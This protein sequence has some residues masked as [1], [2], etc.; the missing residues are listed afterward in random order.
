MPKKS[1]KDNP[2]LAFIGNTQVSEPATLTDD[3][4]VSELTL[5][6]VF[7]PTPAE[8]SESR[9]EY[10][11]NLRLSEE[12]K[13]YLDWASWSRKKSITQYV[14]ELIAADKE[15]RGAEQ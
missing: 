9:R 10:R 15:K 8:K 14:N 3:T 13:E 4:E 12:Y 1:F 5:E 7:T 2:A 6:E 11:I